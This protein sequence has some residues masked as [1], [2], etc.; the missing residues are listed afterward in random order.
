MD[1]P[2]AKPPYDV[3]EPLCPSR[4]AFE[5]IFSRWGILVLARLTEK[6]TRFGAIKRAIGGISE[7]MLAQTL[8]ALE[9]EGLVDR[10]EWNEKPP[11]VEY[12]LTRSGAK[13]SH[14]IKKVIVDLY[15]ELEDLP[16]A[17]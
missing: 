5:R 4:R 3:F 2:K 14:G 17:P 10:R 12:S 9:E 8:K 1:S 11:R 16:R 15:A 13:L 7:R 6:P